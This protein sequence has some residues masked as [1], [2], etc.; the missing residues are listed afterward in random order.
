MAVEDEPKPSC[1]DD[2]MLVFD[3]SGSMAATDFPEGAPSRLDRVRQALFQ[4]LPAVARSRRLGLIV[5]GPG[6]NFDTCRNVDLRLAPTADAGD[7]IM[8]EVEGLR[9]QG[10]TALTTS[11]RQAADL[12]QQGARPAVIVALTDGQDTCGGDACRLAEELRSQHPAITVHVIGYRLTPMTAPAPTPFVER[13]LADA[14]GGIFATAET[15]EQL[16][17]ALSE[18]LGCPAT[19]LLTPQTRARLSLHHWA[20]TFR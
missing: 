12:L 20:L 9:P 10:R 4:V 2:V 6:G 19:T 11:V 16:A 3:A 7:L 17:S 14:T 1:L 5:Y 18:T 8:K 15:S 13:C